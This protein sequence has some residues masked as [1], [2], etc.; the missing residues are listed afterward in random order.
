MSTTSKWIK[1]GGLFLIFTALFLY[2]L[3]DTVVIDFDEGVYAEVSREMFNLNEYIAPILNGGNFFDKPPMLYWAQIA[4]YKLFGVSTLG[5]R[6]FNAIAGILCVLALYFSAVPALGKR[7]AL[8]SA[9]IMA[10]SFIFVYLTRIAMT[11][12]FLTLYLILCLSTSWYAV[13]WTMKGDRKGVYLFWLGCLFSALAMLT[14]GAIGAMF[15]VAT[16]ILY[17]LSIRRLPL[18]FKKNW[19]LPG[20]VILLFIGT[21]W[22]LMLGLTHPEGF[23]FMR[24]LF[25]K[26]HFG[27][28]SSAM[29]GHSGSILYYIPVLIVGMLPWFPYIGGAFRFKPLLDSQS[30]RNRFIRLF[31]IH[32]VLVL[33]F[34][35][36]AATKLPNYI[37]PAIPG[38]AI[39]LAAILENNETRFSR[40]WSISGWCSGLINI[41]LGV[42]FLSLPIILAVLPKYLGDNAFKAPILAQ[43]ISLG[44]VPWIAGLLLTLCGLYIIR[45]T[46][47]KMIAATFQTLLISALVLNL[48]MVFMI[49]PTYDR[50]MNRPLVDI[51]RMAAE[52]TPADGRIIIYKLSKRPSINFYSDRLTLKVKEKQLTQLLEEQ[53][54]QVGITTSY[55]LAQLH[56]E[57]IQVSEIAQ[58]SGYVLFAF[59][60]TAASE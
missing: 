17:L 59:S 24:E 48:I 8:R 16:A 56:E 12:M 42:V 13:E 29:E 57:G 28:F 53:S 11:D 50:L 60:P 20:A 51:A 9:I 27:R 5:A 19:L 18:L 4:G 49:L 2:G 46:R 40:W 6:F 25:I 15:P 21:S 10:S 39:L 45:I 1:A 38:F 47:K 26:H 54:P 14:K 41:L 32:S 7:L 36:L 23:A 37:T 31:V 33:L 55:Y 34:F 3:G 35:S 44:L 58:D 43:P 22:Y 30:P 52:L